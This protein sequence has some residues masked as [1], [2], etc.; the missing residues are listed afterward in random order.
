[1][2]NKISDA[3]DIA[4]KRLYD[5]LEEKLNKE[6]DTTKW[7]FCNFLLEQ[8]KGHKLDNS[9]YGSFEYQKDRD[10]AKRIYRIEKEKQEEGRTIRR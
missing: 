6:W 3:G 10:E 2:E 9:G 8:A 7:E 4:K 5:F 1:M